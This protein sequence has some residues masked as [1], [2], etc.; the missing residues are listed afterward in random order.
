M[1]RFAYLC[2][3]LALAVELL[4]SEQHARLPSFATCDRQHL[5]NM[6]VAC[7]TSCRLHLCLRLQIVD[8]IYDYVYQTVDC[9]YVSGYQATDCIYGSVYRTVDCIYVFVYHDV[10]CIYGC[11]YQKVDCM[12]VYVDHNVDCIFGYIY[13]TVDYIYVW[14]YQTIPLQRLL[15]LKHYTPTKDL[16]QVTRQT[17]LQHAARAHAVGSS[18]SSEFYIAD[19]EELVLEQLSSSGPCFWILV[20]ALAHHLPQGLHHQQTD[21]QS[22]RSSVSHSLTQHLLGP[23]K[24]FE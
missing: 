7:W 23:A 11:A 16:I 10:D 14:D 22:G 13:L 9:I 19:L 3:A 4:V 2:S 20:Q 24:T 6:H 8:C 18:F 15:Q 5:C 21:R 1:T 12:H 17:C